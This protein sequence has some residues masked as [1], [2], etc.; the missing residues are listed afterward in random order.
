MAR[1][2]QSVANNCLFYACYNVISEADPE[3]EGPNALGAGPY[4]VGR[5][6]RQSRGSC[7]GFHGFHGFPVSGIPLYIPGDAFFFSD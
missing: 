3:N 6:C 5:C 1:L 7:P 4:Q 2:D